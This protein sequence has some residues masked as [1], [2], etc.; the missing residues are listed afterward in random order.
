MRSFGRFALPLFL[1]I[2]GP[3]LLGQDSEPNPTKNWEVKRAWVQQH[4]D[5]LASDALKGRGSATS[6]ESVAA[7]YVASQFRGFGLQPAP[8]MSS[9]LQDVPIRRPSLDGRALMSA[10]DVTLHEGADF[11]LLFSGGETITAPLR[12]LGTTAAKTTPPIAGAIVLVTG[13][14]TSFQSLQQLQVAGAKAIVIG[15]GAFSDV[16]ANQTNGHTKVRV[17]LQ[18]DAI[19]PTLIALNVSKMHM[20]A[21][22]EGSPLTIHVAAQPSAVRVLS[23]NAVGY[24][25]GT[26]Q[27]AGALLVSAHLDHLGIADHIDGP[28][29]HGANDDASGVAAVLE[30]AH[31]LSENKRTRRSILFVCFGS[32]EAGELGSRY[33]SDHPPVPLKSITANINLEMLGSHDPLLPRGALI[34]TGWERSNLG[35]A[36]RSHGAPVVPDKDIK[37][38][39]FERSDNYQLALHGVVAQTIAGWGATPTYHQASDDLAHLDLQFLTDCIQSLV[40]PI[41]WLA[42]TDFRPAWNTDGA[43]KSQK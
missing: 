3:L 19:D 30:L 14:V 27:E 15:Q 26:D 35:E 28:I 25:S 36:L 11:A 22:L 5:L 43:P 41:K 21:A 10:N 6:D 18:T 12:V 23:H 38:H 37:Q 7:A 8:G 32:E 29:F 31:A 4:E 34:L 13:E 20:L 2:V 40:V 39:Y 24:L 16:L 1:T 17:R 33:F 9:F 42:S